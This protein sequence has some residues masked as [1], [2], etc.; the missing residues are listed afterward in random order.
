MG[1]RITVVAKIVH[2]DNTIAQSHMRASVCTINILDGSVDPAEGVNKYDFKYIYSY[3]ILTFC[4]IGVVVKGIALSSLMSS[5]ILVVGSVIRIKHAIFSGSFLC[6]SFTLY[7][8]YNSTAAICQL[9]TDSYTI[10]ELIKSPVTDSAKSTSSST[11]VSS[12]RRRKT[13]DGGSA[14]KEKVLAT[15]SEKYA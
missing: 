7:A 3:V 6:C 5:K 14:D 11:S 8:N 15:N 10:F 2:V 1:S 13:E 12:R 9:E 4:S